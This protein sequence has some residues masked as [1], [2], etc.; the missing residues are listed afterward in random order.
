MKT[1]PK[2]QKSKSEIEK[3]TSIVIL[4]GISALIMSYMF[5]KTPI[6]VKNCFYVSDGV[7]LF[8]AIILFIYGILSII[9]CMIP[10][11]MYNK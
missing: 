8:T 4:T 10:N 5:F 6:E 3:D 2:N 11:R 1:K 9:A 7:Y